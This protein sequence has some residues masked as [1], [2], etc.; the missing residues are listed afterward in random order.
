MYNVHGI[1]FLPFSLD[2]RR[3][4]EEI[5]IKE[6]KA[7]RVTHTEKDFTAFDSAKSPI[8]RRCTVL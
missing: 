1:L 8:Y 7:S 3:G 6:E 4:Q 5:C 2:R